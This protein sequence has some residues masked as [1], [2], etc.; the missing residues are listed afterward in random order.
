MLFLKLERHSV[1]RISLSNK[2]HSSTEKGAQYF[3]NIAVR[4]RGITRLL[5]FLSGYRIGLLHK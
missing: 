5:L 2:F 1:V 4:V 3:I